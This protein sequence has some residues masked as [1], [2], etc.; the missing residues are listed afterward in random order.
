MMKNLNE[1]FFKKLVLVTIAIGVAVG[2]IYAFLQIVIVA[3]AI[4]GLFGKAVDVMLVIV[5]IYFL[6]MYGY[7][8]F[9][10]R[11]KVLNRRRPR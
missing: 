6:G 9:M 7:E 5:V 2:T 4:S 10:K 11:K 8:D 1:D 3:S